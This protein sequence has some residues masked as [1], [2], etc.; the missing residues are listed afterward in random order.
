MRKFLGILATLSVVS[1]LMLGSLPA[2]ASESD[3]AEFVA[4]INQ[5]RSAAGLSSLSSFWD[6]VD[7]A[8][9]H[10][11][12]MISAGQIYHS[13]SGQLGSY[14]TGW[15]AL[16][17]NVGLGPNS[18]LLHAAFMNS[19]SHKANILGDYDRIGVG[20][21][22]SP[23][24]TMF[25]TVLFMRSA[26]AP[27]TTTT[28]APATTTTI[29]PTTTTTVPAPTTTAPPVTT[30]TA[31]QAVTTTTVAP[32]TTTTQPASTPTTAAP[33]EAV[34]DPSSLTE[35]VEGQQPA[36]RVAGSRLGRDIARFRP[37]FALLA[38]AAPS[39]SIRVETSPGVFFTI[40]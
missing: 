24:G 14:T 18:A 27:T 40:E 16:G 22:R 32:S 37:I 36:A 26:A 2:L 8:R 23:D 15:A 25:V 6:L 10:T 30:T 34:A 33:P 35:Q 12:E 1:A 31:P 38:S 11:D 20:A 19:A 21:A 4:L 39:E 28:T 29:A 7:D 13:S 3:E 9:V 17:E 5:S